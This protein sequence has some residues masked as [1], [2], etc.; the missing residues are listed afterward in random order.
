[1][2][3]R[4]GGMQFSADCVVIAVFAMIRFRMRVSGCPN[5]LEISSC[6]RRFILRQGTRA[7]RP[8]RGEEKNCDERREDGEGK[9]AKFGLGQ[10]RSPGRLLTVIHNPLQDYFLALSWSRLVHL[11]L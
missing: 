4:T 2:N 3:W 8:A 9:V 5:I 1:M 6:Q 11:P 10:G 7:R